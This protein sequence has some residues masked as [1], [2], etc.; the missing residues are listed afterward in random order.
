[1]ELKIREILP[2][3]TDVNINTF[4]GNGYHHC[5]YPT[6]TNP[7]LH[8]F[9]TIISRVNVCVMIDVTNYSVL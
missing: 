3:D 6:N 1:M 2:S 5:V 7:G 9:N 8:V 4:S